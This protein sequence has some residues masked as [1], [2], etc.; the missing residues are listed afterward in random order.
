LL[1]KSEAYLERLQISHAINFTLSLL[2]IDEENNPFLDIIL[3]ILL[4]KKAQLPRT[5]AALKVILL[6][7]GAAHVA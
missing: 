6:Q 4:V 2:V 1:E 3:Y 5:A 7:L